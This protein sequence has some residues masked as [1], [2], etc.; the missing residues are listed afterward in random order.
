[1]VVFPAIFHVF[2]GREEGTYLHPFRWLPCKRCFRS[3]GQLGPSSQTIHILYNYRASIVKTAAMSSDLLLARYPLS[4]TFIHIYIDR[5]SGIANWQKVL[6][7][8]LSF[9]FFNFEEPSIKHL[10]WAGCPLWGVKELLHR[11]FIFI[12]LKTRGEWSR[13]L[14]DALLLHLQ[15]CRCYYKLL[16]WRENWALILINIILISTAILNCLSFSWVKINFGLLM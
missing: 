7:S 3:M 10:R 2:W 5:I 16:C 11:F 8:H 4:S 13:R 9:F 1:M 15:Q 6:G 12:F 14:T